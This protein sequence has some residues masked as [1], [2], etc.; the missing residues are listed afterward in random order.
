M[1]HLQY[2]S[3]AH[4][5]SRHWTYT[6]LGVSIHLLHICSE[7]VISC[8]HMLH[9]QD[10]TWETEK[11]KRLDSLYPFYCLF[12]GRH[13][14]V[15]RFSCPLPQGGDIT[16]SEAASGDQAK[17][18]YSLFY[19]FRFCSL[20]NNHLYCNIPQT[21]IHFFPGHYHTYEFVLVKKW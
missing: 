9:V 13:R 17:A 6:I 1:P 14:E 7:N 18:I 3:W 15:R 10:K 12:C 16:V 20:E 5:S 19:S 21:D 11:A 4:Q 2:P 8:T